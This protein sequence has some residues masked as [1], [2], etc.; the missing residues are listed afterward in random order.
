MIK[1]LILITPIL[2]SS[3]VVAD[4]NIGIGLGSQIS[5]DSVFLTGITGRIW[6]NERTAIG[7]SY[8][9]SMSE[10]NEND[11][12]TSADTDRIAIR[13]IYSVLG[14]EISRVY[15]GLEYSQANRKSKYTGSSGYSSINDADTTGLSA[16]LGYEGFINKVKS[17]SFYLETGYGIYDR[18]TSVNFVSSSGEESESKE[19]E[20]VTGGFIGVGINFYL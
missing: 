9:I 13:G 12:K 5:Y 15:A 8:S 2:F 4:T 11:D 3:I 6:L 16:I 7:A 14:N 1:K 18:D 20:D 17:G 10:G 19:N